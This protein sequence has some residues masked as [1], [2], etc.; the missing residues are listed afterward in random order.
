MEVLE[1]VLVPMDDL[2]HVPQGK[3]LEKALEKALEKELGKEQER[4]LV[5]VQDHDVVQ[6]C[7]HLS[8]FQ[9]LSMAFGFHPMVPMSLHM[10]AH[11]FVLQPQ[12]L[13]H[14]KMSPHLH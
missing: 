3:V 2:E 4:A 9:G 6:K 12:R 5:E 13:W 7:V 1:H 11:I 8:F 10:A 14:Q